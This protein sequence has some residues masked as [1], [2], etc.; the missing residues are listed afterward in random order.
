M[1]NESADNARVCAD[2]LLEVSVS[3]SS[4]A[5]NVAAQLRQNE[6]WLEVVPGSASVIVQFDA[7]HT[8]PALA[9]ATLRSDL[10]KKHLPSK[11]DA[12][13]LTI[14]VR[15]G[16]EYGP[17]L[18][19]VCARLEMDE[20]AFIR[21]HTS[22]EFRVEML[23]FTPGFAYVGGL[24]DWQ[25]IDRL[26]SPRQRVAAGSIGIAAGRSGIYALQ[27][28]GG[29]PLIGRTGSQLFDPRG[30]QP[31]LLQPGTRVRFAAAQR[32]DDDG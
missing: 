25:A 8:D 24:A 2:D 20:D 22:Q 31:F 16:G 3:N 29:W 23:G 27:G 32:V 17:D 15:Y 13:R 9:L 10:L 12:D 26:E 7:A 28:P 21:L 11:T 1:S 30:D 18:A 5:Q 6:H 19:T 14:D 4:A